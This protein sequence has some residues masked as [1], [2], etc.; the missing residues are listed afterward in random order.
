MLALMWTCFSGLSFTSLVHGLFACSATMLFLYK[1]QYH[2]QVKKS[3]YAAEKLKLK[4]AAVAIPKYIAWLICQLITSGSSVAQEVWKV[5]LEIQP[6]C[7]LAR[8][9]NKTNLGIT[10]LANSITL[11]PGT[12]SVTESRDGNIQIHSLTHNYGTSVKNTTSEDSM[13]RKVS[14]ALGGDTYAI[15]NIPNNHKK[16]YIAQHNQSTSKIQTSNIHSEEESREAL[17]NKQKSES[18]DAQEDAS[19]ELN[20]NNTSKQAARKQDGKRITGNKKGTASKK[21]AVFRRPQRQT[22]K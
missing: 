12:V 17:T 7:V 19:E 20:K 11:T 4:H 13:I 16:N 18:N 10:L 15:A 21:K 2:Q 5:D 9:R 1:F 8:P 22:T 14:E 3:K 6:C